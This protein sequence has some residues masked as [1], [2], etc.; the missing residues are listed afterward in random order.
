MV[1]GKAAVLIFFAPRITRDRSLLSLSPET[2]SLTF[3][4]LGLILYTI[5]FAHMV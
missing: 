4:P 3:L 2:K 1:L 5:V